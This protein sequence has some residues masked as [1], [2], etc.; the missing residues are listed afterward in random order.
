MLI[1]EGEVVLDQS[2]S[3]PQGLVDERKAMG[4]YLYFSKAFDTASRNIIR[5]TAEAWA[6]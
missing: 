5:Q 6:K 3:L 1:L 4:V 2:N